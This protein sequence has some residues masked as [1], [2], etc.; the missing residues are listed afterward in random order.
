MS[1]TFLMNH[2]RMTEI[3]EK[4]WKLA[5]CAVFLYLTVKTYKTSEKSTAKRNCQKTMKQTK[6]TSLLFA[7][8]ALESLK[9]A[10]P[11]TYGFSGYYQEKRT[12]PCLFLKQ[13]YAKLCSEKAADWS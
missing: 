2:I 1:C 7:D 4:I 13:Q 12:K 11:S 6:Q 9:S 5:G 10:A 3:L 8:S